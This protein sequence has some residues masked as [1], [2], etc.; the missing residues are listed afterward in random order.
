MQRFHS[1]RAQ[2]RMKTHSTPHETDMVE[3]R[4]SLIEGFS[5]MLKIKSE[6][7]RLDVLFYCMHMEMQH[8]RFQG[9]RVSKR[10]QCCIDFDVFF[11]SFCDRL[12]FFYIFCLGKYFIFFLCN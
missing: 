2:P 6:E 7:M 3:L 12:L 9:D 1:Q 10:F 11:V 5:F 8:G 4:E